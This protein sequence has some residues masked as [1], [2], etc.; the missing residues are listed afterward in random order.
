MG[1]LLR[2]ILLTSP[3]TGSTSIE[4]AGLPKNWRKEPTVLSLEY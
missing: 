3:R 2:F 4:I 1:M